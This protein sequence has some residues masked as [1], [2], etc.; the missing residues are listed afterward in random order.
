MSAQYLLADDLQEMPSSIFVS[1]NEKK[2]KNENVISNNSE[3]FDCEEVEVFVNEEMLAFQQQ[4]KLVSEP[5]IDNVYTF[6]T[7]QF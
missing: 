4:N 5:L 3:K 7:A 2:K 1:E 6:Q